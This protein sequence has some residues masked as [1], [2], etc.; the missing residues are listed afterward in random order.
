MHKMFNWK[1]TVGA[2]VVIVAL[3]VGIFLYARWDVQRFTESLGEPPVPSKREAPTEKSAGQVSPTPVSE[4]TSVS[5]NPQQQEADSAQPMLDAETTDSVQLVLDAET[6][7]PNAQELSEAELDALLEMF[8]QQALSTLREAVDTDDEELDNTELV[9]AIEE[10]YGPSPEVDVLSEVME[11]I[12]DGTTTLDNLIEM[13]EASSAIMPE[14]MPEG[15]M[16]F[17]KCSERHEQT[18]G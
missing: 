6:T 3:C 15:T 2:A 7:D 12:D 11:R 4:T 8:E 10:A 1:F 5:E 16:S 17:W 18:A 9:D 13:V 14:S